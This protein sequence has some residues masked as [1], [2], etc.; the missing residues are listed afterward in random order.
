MENRIQINGVWYVAETIKS[1]PTYKTVDSLISELKELSEKGYGNYAVT[2][3]G[4]YENLEKI[5]VIEEVD[6]NRIL[7]SDSKY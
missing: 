3:E 1:K 7:L 5:T 2:V 6:D 4:D